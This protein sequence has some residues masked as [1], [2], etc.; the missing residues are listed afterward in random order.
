MELI[1]TYHPVWIFGAILLGLLYAWFL[2]RKDTLLEEISTATK[3]IMASFRLLAVTLIA[4]LLIGIVFERF[5]ERKEKPLVFIA[6]DNSASILLNKDSAYYKNE[7]PNQLTELSAKLSTKFDVVNYRFDDVLKEDKT[8]D[9]QGK[10]TDVSEVFHRIFDQ[11]TNRNIGAII[12]STDGIYNAGANPIYAVNQKSFLPIF[13]IGL[14]DTTTVLDAKVEKVDY[15]EIAFLGNEFPVIVAY[16]G[17]KLK[18]RK[19]KIE[20]YNG[21]TKVG[22]KD[23]DFNTSDAQGEVKFL[24][25]ASEIGYRKLTAR[26]TEF[27]G[28]QTLKNNS[29]SFYIEVIDGRQ[30]IL[31]AAEGPHPDLAALRS[32]IDKNKNYE[33]AFKRFEDVKSTSEYDLIVL[34]NYTAENDLLNKVI[35]NGAV[36]CL[37][38]LG[39]Q[40]NI[41]AIGNM[42]IGMSGNNNGLEEISSVINSNFKEI[43]LSPQVLDLLS[44]VPPLQAPFQGIEYSSALDILAYQKVGS[45]QLESPSIYFTQKSKSRIGVIVGEGIW[46]WKLADQARNK[47]TLN[48][49]EFFGKM[50]TYLA[51][52]ENKDP[53]RVNINN[54]YTEGEQVI[55]SA[56]LYNKSFDLI[57]TPEVSFNYNNEKNEK[58]ESYFLKSNEAYRLELGQLKNGLYNWEAKTTFQGEVYMIK[59]TFLVKEMKIEFLNSVANHQILRSI[60][61]QSNG[62]F[63][64]NNEL[65][66]LADNLLKRDDLV[67]VVYQEKTFDDLIDY[68]WLFVLIVLLLSIEWFMRKY[69]GAY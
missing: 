32:I 56:E 2:Y 12:L 43:V 11:Y 68:K 58:F 27:D 40:S 31:L 8:F 25:K 24:V 28:E 35:E 57:N 36:P 44:M 54:E 64:F 41:N 38:I 30:K 22:Q 69:H 42:K 47:T 4:I 7:Y 21:T 53:F 20:L 17:I 62:E 6:H 34:H 59:G 16:A 45:I 61:K 51:L 5:V 14:G 46:R 26:I 18:G 29:F 67:T 1:Y 9:Y 60:A 23:V 39:N 33:A 65:N 13:T 48:F 52:K 55:V 15:N 3:W 19:A 10:K 66:L 63:Y 50:M 37:F 49:E